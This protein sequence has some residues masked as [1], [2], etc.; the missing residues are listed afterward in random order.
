MNSTRPGRTVSSKGTLLNK[1]R[2]N[3]VTFANSFYCRAPRIWKLYQ[4]T[5]G[6]LTVQ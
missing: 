4:S 3:N 5:S 1:I 2:A 6:T